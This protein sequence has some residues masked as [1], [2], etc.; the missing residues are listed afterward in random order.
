[1]IRALQPLHSAEAIFSVLPGDGRN[2][3]LEHFASVLSLARQLIGCFRGIF[4]RCE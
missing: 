1:M 4:S 3:V 2:M